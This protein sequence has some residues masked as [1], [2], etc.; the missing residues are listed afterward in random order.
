[1]I[2]LVLDLESD[3][4]PAQLSV[5]KNGN[6]QI[7]NFIP[8]PQ[9]SLISRQERGWKNH[10]FVIEWPAN[11]F[12]TKVE[13]KFWILSEGQSKDQAVSIFTE[14]DA[15]SASAAIALTNLNPNYQYGIVFVLWTNAGKGPQSDEVV[16]Q[17]LATSPPSHLEIVNLASNNL[18]VSWSNPFSIPHGVSINGYEWK[19]RKDGVSE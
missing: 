6:E 16:I 15:G 14:V 10:K 5:L 11:D 8:P 2:S 12:V 13:T 9:V 17:T 3:T 19:V 18:L 1:M 4:S 7:A